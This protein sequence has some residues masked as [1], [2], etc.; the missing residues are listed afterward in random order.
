MESSQTIFVES[1]NICYNTRLHENPN[2]PW[3]FSGIKSIVAILFFPGCT[4]LTCGVYGGSIRCPAPGYMCSCTLFF[5]SAGQLCT[6]ILC[7]FGLTCL[8][9]SPAMMRTFAPCCHAYK[10]QQENGK[11]Y[12]VD[13]QQDHAT[14]D[15]CLKYHWCKNKNNKIYT[16]FHGLQ[17]I[18]RSM[19]SWLRIWKIT[20]IS[21]S[22]HLHGQHKPCQWQN[23]ATFW[24]YEG[25]HLTCT[26]NTEWFK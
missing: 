14:K 11:D 21:Q 15:K 3:Y 7:H 16:I 22:K 12:K 5:H 19:W 1:Y 23:N 4:A 6:Y 10:I 17:K 2:L 18:R 8:S 25:Q 26:L 13:I 24:S 9:S 20:Y